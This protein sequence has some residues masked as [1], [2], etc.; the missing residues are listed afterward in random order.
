[1]LDPAQNHTFRDHY[2]EVPLDLSHVLFIATANQLGTLHPALLDRMEILTL[3]GYTEDE[4]KHIARSFLIPRQLSEHGLSAGAIT[5]TDAALSTIVSKYTREAGVRNLERQ[6]G[7]VARKIAARIAS[8]PAGESGMPLPPVELDQPNVSEY[9]G[10][11]RFDRDTVFRTSRPG[12]ATGVAWTEAGGDVLFIEASLLPRGSQNIILTGQLG[13]VMQESARAAVSHIRA[14]ATELGIPEDFLEHRDLH[15]HVPAGAIPKDGPSAGVTMATAILSAARNQ[16][17]REDVAMTGEITLSGLVL[18][19]G[20]IR[21]KALAARRHGIHTF[22][23]PALNAP[24]LEDIPE[25][26]RR[27]MTF[28]P[29]KTLDDVLRA[30]F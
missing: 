19:V 25:D 3:V 13:D 12:V 8:H 5:F 17:T 1:V 24:D 22:I 11:P 29:A 10:R 18:P 4:K 9:L 26:L 21:E 16:A 23:L 20:G 2:L 14:H 15:I 28:I 30:A 7:A 6:I 27:D